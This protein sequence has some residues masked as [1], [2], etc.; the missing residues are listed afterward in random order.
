MPNLL[1]EGGRIIRNEQK[2]KRA[3]SVIIIIQ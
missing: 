2:D 3:Y 1:K